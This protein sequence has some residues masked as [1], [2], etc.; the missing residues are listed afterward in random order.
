MDLVAMSTPTIKKAL[1]ADLM[2]SKKNSK[3]INITKGQ[4][5]RGRTHLYATLAATDHAVDRSA[6]ETNL[7]SKAFRHN[8]Q[9]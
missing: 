2:H 5:N 8:G 4:L 7:E 3:Y 9:K 1:L 6:N